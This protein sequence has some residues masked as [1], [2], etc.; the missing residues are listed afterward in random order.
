MT[1]ARESY[2]FSC[3]DPVDDFVDTLNELS[4]RYALKTIASMQERYDELEEHAGT[5]MYSSGVDVR[6]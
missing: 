4:L 3:L 2:S 5:K 6:D 1:V